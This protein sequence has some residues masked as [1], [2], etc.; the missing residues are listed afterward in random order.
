MG[1]TVNGQRVR[2]AERK[3]TLEAVAGASYGGAKSSKLVD[4]LG[5][6]EK[7]GT[8]SASHSTGNSGRHPCR[9]NVY[10]EPA[11]LILGDFRNDGEAADE[12]ETG[13]KW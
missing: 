13:Q 3:S 5:H 2:D 1:E 8:E 6:V 11:R 7:E 12:N 10:R 9:A 4:T